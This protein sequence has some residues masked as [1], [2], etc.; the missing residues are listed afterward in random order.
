MPTKTSPRSAVLLS[1]VT[2]AYNESKNLPLLY[3]RLKKSLEKL[4]VSWEWI[5]VDDHSA[6]D[7]FDVMAHI[8]RKDKRVRA[9]RFQENRGS[10]LALGFALREARGKCA[11]GIAADLQDPPETIGE[12]LKKWKDGASVVWAV[13]EKRE[14]ESFTTV[15]FARLYYFIVRHL[16]GLKQVPP[17]GADF[18]LL[19]RSILKRLAQARLRNASLLLLICSFGGRQD[20]ILYTKKARAFGRSGWSLQKKL[21]LFFDSVTMFTRAPIYWMLCL[22]VLFLLLG[23]LP[24]LGPCFRS[25]LWFLVPLGYLPGLALLLLG[26][27]FLWKRTLFI[28]EGPLWTVEKRTAGPRNIP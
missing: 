19:D 18:F 17:S 2:P 28:E 27:Y 12:L 3:A 6:D 11:I 20:Q 1:V 13:R 23:M 26:L 25:D 8:A 24:G 9:L 5:V 21:K 7:T 22:G 4:K 10:H 16:V 14:G 15:L